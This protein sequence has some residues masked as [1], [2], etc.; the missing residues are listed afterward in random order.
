MPSRPPPQPPRRGRYTRPRVRVE[1][2][3][4]DL[5]LACSKTPDKGACN[6]PRLGKFPKNS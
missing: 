5:G 3:R 2:I 4:D 1:V 6:N